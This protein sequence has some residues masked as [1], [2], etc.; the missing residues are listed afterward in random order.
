MS[1]NNQG[2]EVT[3]TS[4]GRK[5]RKWPLSRTR[6][7]FGGFGLGL[8]AAGWA[9]GLSDRYGEPEG[10]LGTLRGACR[11]VSKGVRY[12]IAHLHDCFSN[13]GTSVRSLG[14]GQQIE[15]RLCQ[16]KKVDAQQI[17]VHVDEEGTATL[18]GL[19]PDSTHKEKA[20]TLTRDT[21][22]VVRVVDHLAV[23][24]PARV[25]DTPVGDSVPTGVASQTRNLR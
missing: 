9:G 18:R 20:V 8:L 23:P 11:T 12:S 24:P 25:I 13:D 7:V 5:S 14:L 16:D 1:T 10:S 19:V 21:R 22:G 6:C 15:T 2:G 3:T 4:S 17:T